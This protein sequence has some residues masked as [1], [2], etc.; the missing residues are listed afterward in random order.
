MSQ[1]EVRI[2]KMKIGISI[3]DINGIGPEVV[4]KT[5]QDSR[6]C[7]L[8]T[9][10]IY[11]SG[12]VFSF[13][14]SRL[15][16]EFDFFQTDSVAQC[17]PKKPNVINVWKEPVEIHPGEERS[18]GGKYA[19]LS[20]NRAMEDLLSQK[21]HALVTA[22]I[23][24]D[25]MNGE[26]FD[27]P[28]HTEYL[29]EQSGAQESLMLL[30]HDRLRVG[31]VTGHIPVSQVSEKLSTEKIEQKLRILHDSLRNDFQLTKPKIA[32]LGLNPHAG[33]NGQLGTEDQEIILPVIEKWKNEGH[34]I[35]GPFPADGFFG[36][37]SQQNFDAVLGM[38]HD[39]GLIP[40]KTLAFDEGVNYTAGLSI[41]RTSPDHGTGYDIAG[42]NV[43]SPMSFRNAV[44]LAADI[45][46]RRRL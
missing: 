39:Q 32:V 19:I 34:L 12:K 29:T 6:I 36:T 30:V 4:L 9:P 3:G 23:N 21:I 24:K 8:F 28:G 43:A 16:E 18:E 25:L 27:F 46:K 33:E 22:P 15:K 10:V 14:R 42:K 1:T 7:K 13:Y 2:E 5:F 31:V 37:K 45:A 11:A 20:L 35:Y 17:N 26:G 44:Y 38:Y 41:V 40:F